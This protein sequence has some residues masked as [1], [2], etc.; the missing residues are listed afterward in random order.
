[1]KKTMINNTHIEG[2]VYEHKLELK[3]SGANSKHPGTEFINGTLS[4]ATDD[5]CLNVISVHYTYVTAVTNSGKPNATFN[6][7]KAII[8]EKI[9]TVMKHGKENAGKVR[10]DSAIDLNEWYDSRTPGNPLVSNKRNEGG[11]V[12]QVSDLCNPEN[13]STF[14]TDMIITNV[15]RVEA[16]EERQTPEKVIVKGYVFNFRNDVLPVDFSVTFPPAMDYFEG[17]DASEKTPVF[18]KV[19]GVQVSQTSIRTV[20]ETGAWGTSVKQVPTSYRD[21]VITWAQNEPYAWDDESTILASELSEKLAKRELDLA[22]IKK[23]QDEYQASKGAAVAAP[24]GSAVS[25][26]SSDYNF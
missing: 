14:E 19:R 9:G 23:R 17:L 8:D 15:K 16:N 11:F 6:I 18:T 21:F 2:Y 1:M 24:A 12:H 25:K 3:T 4:I 26:K 22:D 10:I 20:E 7:L 13:R 5:D